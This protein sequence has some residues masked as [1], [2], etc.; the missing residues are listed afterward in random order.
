MFGLVP[1]KKEKGE[2]ALTTPEY[3]LR[4]M[5]EEFDA[6]FDRF[7]GGWDLPF[8]PGLANPGWGFDVEDAG[9]ELVVRADAPGFEANDFEVQVTGN[10]LTIRAEHKEEGD[11][12]GQLRQE[13]RFERS[14]TLPAG[15]APNQVEARYRNG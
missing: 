4:R 14:V 6:L 9:N 1:W 11:G 2:G 10:W 12:K 8:E 15:A 7:F 13:R 5:R 3:P